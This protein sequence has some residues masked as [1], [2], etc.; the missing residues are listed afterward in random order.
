MGPR[1]S[2]PVGPPPA[3]ALPAACCHW[4]AAPS[5]PLPMRSAVDSIPHTG[6]AGSWCP[7]VE[8]AAPCLG[9]AGPSLPAVLLGCAAQEE[10]REK[11]P[12]R[13]L[14][15]SWCQLLPCST[16]AHARLPVECQKRRRQSRRS[17]SRARLR[18]CDSWAG[19]MPTYNFKAMQ[20]VPSSKDFMDIGTPRSRSSRTRRA[21]A[22]LCARA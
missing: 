4:T 9:R 2:G 3:G 13:P 14:A 8:A 5:L 1:L 11:L 22:R 20:V 21:V 18:L 15:P 7:R 17:S 16:F 6:S 12:P 19:S 10:R